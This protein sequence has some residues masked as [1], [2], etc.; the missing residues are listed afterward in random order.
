M[1]VRTGATAVA[2]YWLCNF[3]FLP[4]QA[5][6]WPMALWARQRLVMNGIIGVDIRRLATWYFSRRDAA[7]NSPT[8]ANAWEPSMRHGQAK[9]WTGRQV[10]SVRW[11]QKSEV[12]VADEDV[13]MVKL[14]L[15]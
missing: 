9:D 12:N 14:K 2:L 13:L 6:S 15:S 11:R 5:R 7:E 8:R 1:A 10:E 4:L 3:V